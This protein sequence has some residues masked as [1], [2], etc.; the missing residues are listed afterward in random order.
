[1]QAPNNTTPI[2]DESSELVYENS[3]PDDFHK[4]YDLYHTDSIFQLEHTIFPLKG[5]ARSADTTKIAE[6]V[7]WQ[8]ED[9][10]QH[11][12]F[13]DQNGTFER[14]FTNIG[15][16]ITEY[17]SANEGLFSLEK[18]YAKLGE[19]WFLIYYQELLMHG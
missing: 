5:L 15:G 9:W 18:R 11:K 14:T 10:I 2:E 4:F 19:D 17:I 13:N 7:L 8:K 6:E 3:L 16:I 1:M 12:P